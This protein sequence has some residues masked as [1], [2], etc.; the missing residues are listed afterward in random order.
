[1]K[2]RAG[3]EVAKTQGERKDV[4]KAVPKPSLF[5]CH[6]TLIH[7]FIYIYIYLT[8]K[9]PFVVPPHL[10]LV[11]ITKKKKKKKAPANGDN[12]DSGELEGELN[13][14]KFRAP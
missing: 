6:F 8:L 11:K 3:K 14:W 5:G 4:N 1:M 10:S 2:L 7:T 12:G 13:Q 9:S